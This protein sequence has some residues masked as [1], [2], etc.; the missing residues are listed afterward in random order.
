MYLDGL[1]IAGLGAGMV[2]LALVVMLIATLF[3]RWLIDRLDRVRASSALVVPTPS[4][5]EEPP[6]TIPPTTPV[7]FAPSAPDLVAPAP[8]DKAARAAAI[9]VALYLSEEEEAEGRTDR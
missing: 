4:A 2:F 6:A 3:L 1:E 8:K 7:E 9:A 5:A